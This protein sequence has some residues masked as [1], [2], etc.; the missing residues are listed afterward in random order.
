MNAESDIETATSPKEI[1]GVVYVNDNPVTLFDGTTTALLVQLNQYLKPGKNEIRVVDGMER[2]WNVQLGRAHQNSST[3]VLEK[4]CKPAKGEFKVPFVLDDVKWKLPIFDSKI[5]E[6]VISN[7]ALLEILKG[8]FALFSQKDKTQIMDFLGKNG[9]DIWMTSAY[10]VSRE[11]VEKNKVFAKKYMSDV[12]S[13]EKFPAISE[14]KIIRGK[15]SI[16]VYNGSSKKGAFFAQLRLKNGTENNLEP[17]M[18]YKKMECGA[19]GTKLIWNYCARDG[20]AGVFLGPLLM[21]GSRF[22]SVCSLS[23]FWVPDVF[24]EKMACYSLPFLS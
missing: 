5:P 16:L 2:S 6:P 24:Q 17:L 22:F 19:C 21:L 4:D 7:N 23:G 15:N 14:L 18:L 8:K 12:Q 1:T 3:V 20:I 10:G 11:D 13:V 9:K